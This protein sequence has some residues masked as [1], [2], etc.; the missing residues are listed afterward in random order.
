MK[1][2]PVT[3]VT[4]TPTP[5]GADWH[6]ARSGLGLRSERSR[7]LMGALKDFWRVFEGFLEDLIKFVKY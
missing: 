1:Q 6:F 7:S 2:E 4:R 5:L 3:C